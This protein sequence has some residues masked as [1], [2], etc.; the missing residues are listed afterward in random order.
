MEQI[1]SIIQ[2]HRPIIIAFIVQDA[3]PSCRLE[4]SK[5]KLSFMDFAGYPG[6]RGS[7][8]QACR[9]VSSLLLLFLLLQDFCRRKLCREGG[10]L[11]SVRGSS[12]DGLSVHEVVVL[13]AVPRDPTQDDEPHEFPKALAQKLRQRRGIGKVQRI[14]LHFGPRRGGVPLENG[15]RIQSK[16][17]VRT[18]PIIKPMK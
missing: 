7:G 3:Y 16:A 1:I 14:Q 10:V 17:P 11:A 4:H 5:P 18:K 8:T 12:L 9:G 13:D 15:L 6:R 2:W